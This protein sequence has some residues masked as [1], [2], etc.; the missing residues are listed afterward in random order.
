LVEFHV[1]TLLLPILLAAGAVGSIL[2]WRY[3][4][5]LIRHWREPVLRD[6]VVIIESDD[7][8][9]G[10]A[11][12]AERLAAVCETLSRY[13]DATGRHP[14]MT[15]GLVLAVPDAAAI[16]QGNFAH[17]QRRT[18]AD[19]RYAEI[20]NVLRDGVHRGVLALQLHGLEHLWP[21][22]FM[23]LARQNGA[24]RRWLESD[25]AATETLPPSVQSRWIDGS[26]LPSRPLAASAIQNEA[27]G[28]VAAF[29][30]LCGR[31]PVVA[32]PPTFIW[33]S[34]V[35]RAWA[36]AGVRFVV[37]PGRRNTGRNA[38]GQP[39]GVDRWMS[40]GEIGDGGVC[41]LVRDLYFEPTFG[42]QA[43]PVLAAI[44][45]RAQ[46]GRPALLETHRCNFLGAVAVSENSRRELE[47]LLA[48]LVRALPTVRFM[49]TEELGEAYRRGDS[50]FFEQRVTMRM[51]VWLRRLAVVERL[52]K[53][54]GIWV[55]SVWPK[56]PKSRGSGWAGK[57]QH[58]DSSD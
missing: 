7:W 45:E 9:P 46:L 12:Q 49:S 44:R 36:T 21:P 14:V 16:R 58:D 1:H 22:A 2:V 23:K 56:T 29:A 53:L 5:I 4:A 38:Q 40:N 26:A 47:R 48:G 24:V 57:A 30:R 54:A 37:T 10:A 34:E 20:L 3:G 19:P 35:E 50:E 42:H 8:G 27:R 32:V 51:R 6:P 39:G 11:E 18:L 33:N 43:E 15:V 13:Q 31:P 55:F 25:D 28:E 52:R 17:Y 41:Y